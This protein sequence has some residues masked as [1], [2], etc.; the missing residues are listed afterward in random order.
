MCDF[1][2]SAGV[3]HFLLGL[4]VLSNAVSSFSLFAQE[5]RRNP[6]YPR[7]QI[8]AWS[9]AA[10]L[11]RSETHGAYIVDS[12]TGKI[13][14]VIGEGEPR[15]LGA[16]DAALKP[17]AAVAENG[18][19]SAQAEDA[20][21]H[22]TGERSEPVNERQ[23]GQSK[24]EPLEERKQ[25]SKV[26]DLLLG[27]SDSELQKVDDWI[28]QKLYHRPHGLLHPPYYGETSSPDR[29]EMEQLIPLQ[30]RAR[31]LIDKFGED[32]V[33]VVKGPRKNNFYIF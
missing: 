32:H 5:S 16:I 1:M 15:E 29:F 13:W 28:Q 22:A 8:A 20:A 11:G 4:V 18:L 2:R 21:Q 30:I 23:P 7:Y 17:L 26:E 27:L 31:L 12:Q 3:R 25:L 9:H 24:Q 19:P 10:G 14:S 6:Y 33:A